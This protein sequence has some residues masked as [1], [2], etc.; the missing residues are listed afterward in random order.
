VQNASPDR[1]AATVE[2]VSA[3]AARPLERAV[4]L[5]REAFVDEGFFQ[6]E[7]ER[8]FRPGWMCLAHV[9]ELPN[10]G[11]Y[12]A[13]ELFDEPLLV[14]RGKDQAVRVLS[15]VCAH[16]S[17]DIMPA[18]GMPR[19]GTTRLLSCPYH[20][21]T[22]ELDGR[23]RGCAHMENAAAFDRADWPLPELRSEVWNGFVFVNLDGEAGS[24]AEQYADFDAQISAW[25]TEEMVVAISMDWDCEFNWKVM[26]ENWLESYHHIGAHS[27]TLNPMMPGQHTWTEPEHPH[28]VR[29][30][31]PYTEE[32]K[33]E[34][35]RAET[36][37]AAAGFR[38]VPGLSEV[39]QSEWGLYVGHPCFMFL[40]AGDRVI[41][42]RLLPISAGRCR[43]Q[44]M[45][46]VTRETAT[47]PAYAA[48]LEAE[49]PL[50]RDF[51]LEDMQMNAGVQKGMASRFAGGGPLSHLEEPV[52]LVQRYLAARLN[53]R[54]P[55][56]AE[57]APYY[58]PLAGAA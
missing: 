8:V 18:A 47:D 19:R 55:Q 39:Q 2:R 13:L 38:R 9:S 7:V 48:M 50:M 29:A 35:R 31:L 28:F 32:L 20:A 21:W 1:L 30:H 33:A 57:R 56:P 46:L 54:F 17:M 40:T 15:R 37:G 36:T 41:W 42:Y 4:A 12:L 44:T 23:L 16:R 14:I 22:Y 26:V 52:W 24:L 6:L 43:L 45:T 49:T 58:G 34:L 10:P 25:K 51:H 5:P 27:T 11:D 3:V 53:G